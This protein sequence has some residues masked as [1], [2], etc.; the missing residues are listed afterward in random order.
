[1]FFKGSLHLMIG[2]FVATYRIKCWY[3]GMSSLPV[4]L[5]LQKYHYTYTPMRDY[6]SGETNRGY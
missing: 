4:C 6:K 3:C 1:M 5:L 2:G